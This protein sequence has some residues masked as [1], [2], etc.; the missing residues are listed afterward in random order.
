MMNI[1]PSQ[2]QLASI[3]QKYH[4]KKLAL[5][6]SVL[7]DDFSDDSD[8]DVLVEFEKGHTPD[9]FILYDIEQALS[10]VFG[11]RKIDL[12]TYRALNHHLR[13]RILATAQVQYEQ[14]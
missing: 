12:V 7:R 5:F 11:G 2:T 3:C 14:R 10:S 6:G 8:V 9:F 4:I 1:Y 13:G